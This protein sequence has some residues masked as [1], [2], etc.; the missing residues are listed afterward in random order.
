MKPGDFCKLSVVAVATLWLVGCGTKANDSADQQNVSYV[1]RMPGSNAE[2][3][4]DVSFRLLESAPSARLDYL[5]QTIIKAGNQCRRITSGVLQGGLDGTDEWRVA[6][7]D[8]GAWAV[9]FTVDGRVDVHPCIGDA[10]T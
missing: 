8:T 6:C 10:C 7:A 3:T 9:W 1:S 5:Q 2:P 4:N